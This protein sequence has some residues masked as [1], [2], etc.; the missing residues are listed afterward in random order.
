M[1]ENLKDRKGGCQVTI[2]G[3]ELACWEGF[4]YKLRLLDTWLNQASVYEDV[5]II[6]LFALR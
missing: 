2:D 1:I 3:Q 4:C 5:S 6:N